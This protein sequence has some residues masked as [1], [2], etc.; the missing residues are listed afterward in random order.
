MKA[1]NFLLGIA[2]GVTAGYAATRAYEAMEA[3]RAGTRER[4]RDAA[5][6]GA[7]RRVFTMSGLLRSLAGS[8]TLAYGPL[9]ARF[10][11]SVQGLPV[12]LRPMVFVTES[13]LLDLLLELPI[14]FVE[15]YTIERRYGLSEQSAQSWLSDHLKQNAIGIGVSALLSGGLAAAL[16]KFPR[17]WPYVAGAAVL[18]LLVIA[19][20][21]IPL[22]ILPMFNKYEP[23][24]GDLER[25]LR[26]LAK[27]YG[28]GDAE[29]LRM[30]MSKQT[31][32]ANAFVIGIGSTHRICV[33][34]TLIEHFPEEE[35]EFVVAHELGHYVS[36]D[37]WRMIAAGELAAIVLLFGAFTM[38]EAGDDTRQLAR[39][40]LWATLFSH[41]LRPALSAFARS[42]EWAADRFAL[43]AT[44]RAHTG[45]SAF[46]RLRD[47]NL[48]EDEQPAWY[49]FMF[50]T[51]PSLKAR[52]D[53]LERVRPL[54]VAQ[55]P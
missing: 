30:N 2:A 7:L 54:W 33:G 24:E 48:A 50:S 29:I 23:L 42:R 32:K 11:R 13:A 38:V 51:H 17:T 37:T 44:A 4:P 16:R 19:N 43:Q 34:D 35:I 14:D 25:R 22:Y 31:K 5:Q 52:I 18:P 47:Q 55:T 49:E 27:R 15:G 46:R 45:A 20:L 26:A 36:K 12:W 3:L 21:V 40:Q 9:G 53:A 28:V 10:E 41:L 1:R 8:V 39:I 6:Y